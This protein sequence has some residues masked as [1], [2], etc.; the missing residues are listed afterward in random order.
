MRK[1][2]RSDDGRHT[3]RRCRPRR[4][5]RSP[6]RPDPAPGDAP[7]RPLHGW[8]RLSLRGPGRGRAPDR[9]VRPHRDAGGRRLPRPDHGEGARRARGARAERG[10]GRGA[11]RR[12]GRVP[13]GADRL[14]RAA[15]PRRRRRRAAGAADGGGDDPAGRGRCLRRSG[16]CGRG[17]GVRRG[18]PD[19]ALARA[20]RARYRAA[21]CRRRAGPRRAAGDG[22]RPAHLSVRPVGLRQDVRAR[23][24]SGA[25][26]AGDEPAHRRHRSQCRFRPPRPSEIVRGCGARIW[27]RS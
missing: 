1:L 15:A 24:D 5:A 4:P 22:V 9:R 18:V 12:A 19:R 14:S 26:A 25:A 10:R 2:A 7:A 20:G 27:G 16:D 11:G 23:G 17:D 13:G 21:L 3:R 6:R 8:P